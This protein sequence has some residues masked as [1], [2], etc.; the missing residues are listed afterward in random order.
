[1][2]RF[3]LLLLLI[4]LLPGCV[5]ADP[6]TDPIY[7]TEGYYRLD[8]SGNGGYYHEHIIDVISISPGGSGATQITPNASSLGGYQLNAI[9]ELLYFNGHVE[10]DWDTVTDGIL[11]IYFEVNDDNSAGLVTDTVDLQV[12]TWHKMEGETVCTVYSLSGSTVVGQSQQHDLFIQEIA[13]T[14]LRVKEVIA[15]RLNLNT[16]FSEVDDIIVNH[17]VF[18]YQSMSPSQEVS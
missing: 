6:L 4:I 5:A 15:F 17:I 2:R 7:N 8:A 18:A 11:E 12:E 14:N 10:D 3:A 9:N 13:V 16:I 1:M